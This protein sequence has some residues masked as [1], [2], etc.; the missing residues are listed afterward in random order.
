M[1][2]QYL[3]GAC[4]KCW[5]AYW[6]VAWNLTGLTCKWLKKRT[7]NKIGQCNEIKSAYDKLD[8]FQY[9]LTITLS[10]SLLDSNITSFGNCYMME[11][12]GFK[13]YLH[14]QENICNVFFSALF[15]TSLERGNYCVWEHLSSI[16]QVIVCSPSY[17]NSSF[18]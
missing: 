6:M 2:L 14:F 9:K 4:A 11:L 17:D 1:C 10:L 15:I 16:Q 12:C 8:W 18:Q 7:T 3:L 13:T 5:L